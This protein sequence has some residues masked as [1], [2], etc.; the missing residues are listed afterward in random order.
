MKPILYRILRVVG[1]SLLS[2]LLLVLLVWTVLFIGKYA[3]YSDYFSERAVEAE[4]PGI[5]SGFCPQGITYMEEHALYIHSGYRGPDTILYITDKDGDHAR[6]I[7]LFNADGTP[8]QT[9]GGGL[10]HAGGLIYVASA[11]GSGILTVFRL[12][13]LLMVGDE[14]GSVTAIGNFVS[15]NRADFCFADETSLYVGEFYRPETQYIPDASHAYTTPEGEDNRA[16]VS[17]YPISESGEVISDYPTYRI[18][19]P[20]QVQGFVIQDGYAA[21]STSWGLNSSYL[22]IYKGLLPAGNV[23][24]ENGEEIPLYYLG[25]RNQIKKVKMPAFS[26]ELDLVDGRLVISFESAANKY[27]IG[28]PFFAD[29]L[30][31]YPFP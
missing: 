19:I 27:I 13:D 23:T 31:S 5:P 6:E 14:G 18:S 3:I 1:L 16:I 12:S 10:T 8:T 9:H 28:K 17:R 29:K 24:L 11:D 26:E 22:T 25:A 4:I 30:V 21:I 15:D 20:A 2:L 7:T